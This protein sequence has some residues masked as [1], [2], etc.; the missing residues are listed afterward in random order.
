M[1]IKVVESFVDFSFE[2][3]ELKEHHIFILYGVKVL[4]ESWN[5]RFIG[6]T[7][8]GKMSKILLVEL[9]LYISNS[10]W[11]IVGSNSHRLR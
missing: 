4:V 6:G 7:V 3:S 11:Q 5:G 1:M 9:P 2:V 8:S 10:P